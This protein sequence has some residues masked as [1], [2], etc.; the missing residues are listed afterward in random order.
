MEILVLIVKWVVAAA[1][2][3][4]FGKFMW[5]KYQE[6]KQRASGPAGVA[7]SKPSDKPTHLE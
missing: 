2:I 6:M 3:G 1:V 5:T 4:F 7:G